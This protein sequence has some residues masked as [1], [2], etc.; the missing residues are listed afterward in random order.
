M[1]EFCCGVWQIRW[2]E[3]PIR[4]S[5][6]RRQRN[7]S[8]LLLPVLLMGFCYFFVI[9]FIW[10]HLWNRFCILPLAKA[11][12]TTA[13]QSVYLSSFLFPCVHSF[14]LILLWICHFFCY[15]FCLCLFTSPFWISNLCIWI[16]DG[17]RFF[18]VCFSLTTDKLWAVFHW[19]DYMYV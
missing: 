15:Y 14:F 9:L 7:V 3:R 13:S 2:M 17:L 6:I 18:L 10:I 19:W 16:M 8:T 5:F 12:L 4:R 1:T 11:F